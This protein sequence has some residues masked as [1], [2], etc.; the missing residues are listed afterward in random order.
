MTSS[1]TSPGR[2]VVLD[3]ATLTE[4]RP[5]EPL[6]GNE[7]SWDDLGSLVS[8]TVHPR[9]SPADLLERA[10]GARFLLTNKVVLGAEALRE[11]GELRYIGVMATGTNIVELEAARSRGIVVTNVP[12]YATASV[13]SHVM[14]G[15]LAFF[16]RVAD[17]DTAVHQGDWSRCP[18][19]TFSRGP[20]HELS[21]RTLGIVGLG[22]IGRAVARL[23]QAFGMRVIAASR[24]CHPSTNTP[25]EFTEAPTALIIPRF[26]LDEVFSQAD[27]VSLHCPLTDE[28][29]GMVDA[30]RLALM[31]RSA[32]LVNTARG[33]LVDEASLAG[34]L[35]QGCLAGAALD[36][37]ST[38]PPSPDNPLLSAPRCL[39]T[40][41]RAWATEDARKRLMQCITQNLRCFLEGTPRNVVV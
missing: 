15:I 39:I 38:E 4:H 1:P 8:L 13:S 29:R 14:A 37:L 2:C 5:A 18:D 28:T 20:T 32:L 35:H 24:T 23:G 26:A 9:T 22:E 11:L 21:G 33:G 19:F 7:P 41:H 17:H 3:G 25:R 30:R 16:C 34:A 31:K 36:V 10:S 6:A 12:S 40:P 27:V